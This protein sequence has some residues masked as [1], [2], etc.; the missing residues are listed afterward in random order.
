VLDVSNCAIDF[1]DVNA[2]RAFPMM[3]SELNFYVER[4]TA[5]DASGYIHFYRLVVMPA[6][7][8]HGN[9]IDITE[10]NLTSVNLTPGS[11]L[12]TIDG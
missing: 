11:V 4:S 9:K 7:F 5:F 1:V 6:V 12:A 8:L 10:I 2:W 3:R